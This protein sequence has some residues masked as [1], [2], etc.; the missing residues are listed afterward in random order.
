MLKKS[1]VLF[2]ISDLSLVAV[3]CEEDI[4]STKEN[5]TLE[6]EILARSGRIELETDKSVYEYGEKVWIEVEDIEHGWK[7][8][9]WGRD[10]I[11]YLETRF[12]RS[13]DEARIE[14]TNNLE[15]EA[16]FEKETYEV[17]FKVEGE[18]Y[19]SQVVKHEE[20]STTPK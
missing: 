17:I 15:L 9:Q 18:E 6:A 5:Y 4:S 12:S 20:S 19:D 7:F 8:A 10:I 14:V 11:D 2:F 16:E 13:Q 1:L 3:G